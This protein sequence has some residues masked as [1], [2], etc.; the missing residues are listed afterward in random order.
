VRG[1]FTMPGT[2]S[3]FG[4]NVA[5]MDIYAAQAAFN[6]GA[7]FDRIDI[8]TA[9]SGRLTGA[10]RFTTSSA[11]GVTSCVPICAVKYRERRFLRPSGQAIT[12]LLALPS[13]SSSSS[14]VYIS[15]NQ[16]WKEIGILRSLGSLAAACNKCFSSKRR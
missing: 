6:R 8:G 12:S 2:G 7:K 16:R 13:V 10:A 3:I 11:R 9:R 5:V 4:G 14:T 15:V 1:F